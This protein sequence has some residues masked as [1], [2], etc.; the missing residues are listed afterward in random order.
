MLVSWALH[1]QTKPYMYHTVDFDNLV[2]SDRFHLTHDVDDFIVMDTCPHEPTC[3]SVSIRKLDRFF[4]VLDQNPALRQYVKSMSLSFINTDSATTVKMLRC[5][6]SLRLDELHYR[7]PVNLG[8]LSSDH[9]VSIELVFSK[10]DYGLQR[11]QMYHVFNV[12]TLAMSASE[13]PGNG[14]HSQ[15]HHLYP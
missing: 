13:V 15:P 10:G 7:A 6:L 14:R 5:L 3:N 1:D 12:P 4:E 8:V 9:M 2:E 11:S